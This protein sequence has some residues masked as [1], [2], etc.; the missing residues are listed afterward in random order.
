MKESK[1]SIELAILEMDQQIRQGGRHAVRMRLL[2]Y[3]KQ[4]VPRPYWAQFAEL[5]RRVDAPL[6]ALQIL[7]S[8]VR[9][10]QPLQPPASIQEQATYAAALLRVD[11]IPEAKEILGSL[12]P[13]NNPEV[14]LYRSFAH[15]AEWDHR[16]AIPH[17]RQYIQHVQL[18]DYQ[19]LVG[20]V[21]LALAFVIEMRAPE[22]ELLL[23]ELLRETAQAGHHLLHGNC[24]E[25][26]AQLHLFLRQFPDTEKNLNLANQSLARAGREFALLLEKWRA[27]LDLLRSPGSSSLDRLE[28]IRASA[29]E[30]K[31]WEIVRDCDLYRMIAFRDENLFVH[32]SFGT[33]Y[34]GFHRRMLALCVHEFDLPNQ[35]KFS[36]G[37][38]AK[39]GYDLFKGVEISA[40]GR[41]ARTHRVHQT[42]D[43][44]TQDFYRPHSLGQLFSNLYPTE[45]F[46]PLSS[47]NRVAQSLYVLR[48]WFQTHQ[49]PVTVEA[50]SLQYRLAFKGPYY[51]LLQR[52]KIKSFQYAEQLQI[53]KETWPYQSFTKMKAE[54]L[55]GSS[56]NRLLKAAVKAKHLYRSGVGRGTFYRFRK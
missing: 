55:L 27:I 15:F 11:A 31:E 20:R 28:R 24:L 3:Q 53:L 56:P 41:I 25:L 33:R 21:N 10:L 36:S 40:R 17:L 54:R 32:L 7:R 14:L 22:A 19:R 2:A 9:P 35:Y 18:S 8:V 26:T 38:S 39:N 16:K 44:L 42:L 47:R 34:L 49:I 48:R 30:A 5:A 12:S 51:F 43:C 52:T 37:S 1:E 45:Y 46:N 6:L 13:A 29:V 50:L 4:R 23:N